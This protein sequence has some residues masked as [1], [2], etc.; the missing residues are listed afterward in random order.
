MNQVT[1]IVQNSLYPLYGDY[2]QDFPPLPSISPT[3]NEEEVI[4]DLPSIAEPSI[5]PSFITLNPPS[6]E[7]FSTTLDELEEV[8]NN[9]F[10]TIRGIRSKNHDL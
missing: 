2:I 10:L 7:D 5:S 6:Q 9:L 3:P 4:N 1:R 8:I